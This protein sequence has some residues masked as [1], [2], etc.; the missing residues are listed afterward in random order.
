MCMKIREMNR[1]DIDYVSGITM[2]RW[3]VD[4]EYAM[5]EI[6][7]WLNHEDNSICFVGI[8]D[9]K[10]M[11]TGVFDTISDDTKIDAY[12]T[13]LWVEPRY[14]GKGYGKMMVDKRFEYA[15]QKGYKKVYLDT[16]Y[17]EKYHLKFGW[18]KIKDNVNWN[19]AKVSIMEYDLSKL[20]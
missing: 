11:A 9:G 15:K 18:K 5:T 1:K 8:I 16:K 7:R 19:G 4:R 10:P 13:L 12:N 14:R 3:G 20:S 17:A 6:N 2:K